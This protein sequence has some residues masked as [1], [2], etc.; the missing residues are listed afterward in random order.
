MEQSEAKHSQS[1]H[2]ESK[3]PEQAFP[4]LQ[5]PRLTLGHA[6]TS[7]E[8]NRVEALATLGNKASRG[9]LEKT[10]FTL[11]GTLRQYEWARGKFQDQWIFSLLKEEWT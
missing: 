6:F 2:S 7:M 9:I 10:G 8:C 1:K 4:I 3:Q 5:T 11:E